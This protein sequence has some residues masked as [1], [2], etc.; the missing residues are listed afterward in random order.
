MLGRAAGHTLRLGN[1]VLR[2]AV[3][4]GPESLRLIQHDFFCPPL[5]PG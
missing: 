4:F 2:S 3:P 5:F 1:Q